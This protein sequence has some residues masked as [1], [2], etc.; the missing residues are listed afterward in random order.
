MKLL[1]LLA[2]LS[3]QSSVENAWN[4]IAAGKRDEAKSLLLA[5]VQTEAQNAEAHLLLGSLL[6]ED[7]A[8]DDSLLHLKEGVRLT[9]KSAAA[10]NALGEA[11]T[12]FANPKAARPEFE[13]AVTLDPAL[14]Q[15]HVN[16][17]AILLEQG[18]SEA[19]IPHL[20]KALRHFAGKP[21]A[22]YPHYLRA[23]TYNTD[24]KKAAS[25][26][27]RAVAL[28]PDFAEAWSDLGEARKTLFNDEGAL[29]AYRRAV[30]LAPDDAIA[31]TRLGAALLD[32]GNAHEAAPHLEEAARL[33]PTNQSALNALQRALR[34]DGQ[35]QKAEAAKKRL[36]EV[37]LKRA[38]DDQ[39]LVEAVATNNAGAG[40][41]K[42]GD[43][44]AAVA[45]YRTALE[46]NPNHIGIRTNLA[47]ALLKLGQWD[48]GLAQL[49]EALRRNPTDA[50][51]SKALDDALQQY[52]ARP[53]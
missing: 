11:Y 32:A 46:L 42:K 14:A 36:A 23:K 3:A 50:T 6:M 40:L 19:A 37:L 26:L 16:L 17:A 15:A 53:K 25:E 52:Q 31:Q 4:L 44:P 43:L 28:R 41:E 20:D 8:K 38:T 10:H 18:E 1:L 21:D 33:D 7:G 49:K 34:E 29:E 35:I 12:T 24:A 13:R 9:P 30:K 5:L 39:K 47:V 45:K 51:L 2:L 27:E 48:E 22:A